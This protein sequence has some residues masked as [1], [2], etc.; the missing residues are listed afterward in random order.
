PGRGGG[1][2]RAARHAYVSAAGRGG[3]R[4]AHALHLGR[5]RL[6]GRRARAL[7]AARRG[8]RALRR[9]LR[10]GGP[11]RV[12][13]VG[14]DGGHPARAGVLAR[15][16]LGGPRAQAAGGEARARE[17]QRP[18][19]QGP[20]DTGGRVTRI[21]ERFARL[22]ARGGKAFVAFVTAG[23]PSLGRTVEIALA[24]DAAGADVLELGGPF[25][26]PLP[27]RPRIPRPTQP[28]PR[29]G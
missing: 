22:R 7:L 23:D 17:P 15:A 1:G 21:S 24:L 9:R 26:H 29:Q 13:P 14:G 27:D 8:T 28:P 6:P 12:P 10:R 3:Q 18:R 16:G 4:A 20:R 11:A 25:S 19:R 5:A 2:G